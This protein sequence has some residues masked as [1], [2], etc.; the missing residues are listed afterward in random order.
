MVKY[1]LVG[2]K[3][4]A[5]YTHLV[6]VQ[7]KVHEGARRR[8]EGRVRAGGIFVRMEEC[9]ESRHQMELPLFS[10][11]GNLYGAVGFCV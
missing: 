6:V 1:V 8:G 10:E 2:E 7:E 5:N 4:V 9:V 3:E 11:C